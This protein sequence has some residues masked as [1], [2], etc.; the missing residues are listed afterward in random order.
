MPVSE[1]VNGCLTEWNV[2][3]FVPPL[4]IGYGART[5]CRPIVP[6][7]VPST[8]RLVNARMIQGTQAEQH[9]RTK[10]VANKFTKVKVFGCVIVVDVI[11][12]GE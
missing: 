9:H 2:G 11:S 3:L 1:S 5:R 7:A 6:I 8:T 10:I 12:I 4:I